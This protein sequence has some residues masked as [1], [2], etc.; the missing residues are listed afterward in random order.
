MSATTL[1]TALN[2]LGIPCTVQAVDRLAIIIPTACDVE[3]DA[4]ERRRAALTLMRA[5]GFTHLAVEVGDEFLDGA[6]L[7]RD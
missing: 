4:P 2:A 6:T 5:H 7:R 1:E 3:F